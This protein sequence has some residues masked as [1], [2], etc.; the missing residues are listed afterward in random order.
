MLQAG[1]QFF[2]D[3][4]DGLE[5]ALIVRLQGDA[6]IVR[7]VI[8][9]ILEC[10]EEVLYG[11]V[12]DTVSDEDRLVL[13]SSDDD[14]EYFVPIQIAKV[15]QDTVEERV[16]VG[17]ETDGI[18]ERERVIRITLPVVKLRILPAANRTPVVGT[19]V[20]EDSVSIEVEETRVDAIGAGVDHPELVLTEER[21]LGRALVVVEMKISGP[22]SDDEV[23]QTV[24]I[25][26]SEIK[27]L[28][29]QHKIA[30]S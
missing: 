19:D 1:N 23:E 13:S 15:D 12:R 24:G 25:D 3:P 2:Q 5:Q 7:V 26:I 18:A 16:K 30:T 29:P 21:K 27:A 9:D 11:F 10:S 17:G 28:V 8:V 20:V 22:G 6:Q 14:V 4:I